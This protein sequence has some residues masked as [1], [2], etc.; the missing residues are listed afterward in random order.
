VPSKLIKKALEGEGMIVAKGK[1]S[2]EFA[3]QV[4]IQPG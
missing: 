3:V 4:V 2:D 1:I